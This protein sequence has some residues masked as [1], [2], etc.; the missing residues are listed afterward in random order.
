MQYNYTTLYPDINILLIDISYLKGIWI[1]NNTIDIHRK[2]WWHLSLKRYKK[3]KPLQLSSCIGIK[4]AV[5]F[6][7]RNASRLLEKEGGKVRILVL[8]LLWLSVFIQ[9]IVACQLV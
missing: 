3:Q 5:V 1:Y 6:F 8:Y 9:K 4:I 7:S 2:R